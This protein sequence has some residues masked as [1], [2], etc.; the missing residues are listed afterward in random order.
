MLKY[1]FALVDGVPADEANTEI[2]CRRVCHVEPTLYGEMY[3]FTSDQT[4]DDT[5]YT[6]LAIGAH[7]DSTY[8][9]LP[10][11]IQVL[12]CTYHDG[13]GGMSLL[14]DGFHV[15]EQLRGQSPELFDILTRVVVPHEYKATLNSQH[16]ITSLDSILKIHPITKE[17]IWFRYNHYDRAPINSI[18]P[19]E[20]PKF[21]AAINELSKMV[22]N[23]KQE[24][25]F[26]LKP[27]TVLFMDNFRV[28]H[29]R[30]A[31]TGKRCISGCYL[32]RDDWMS[33]ARVFGL[34]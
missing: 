10:M 22:E 23:P 11:G 14:L 1:G 34:V 26:K 7:T 32:P 18:P 24:M 31:F 12:H 16:H 30:S 19:E 15:A 8:F 6:N 4:M 17:L 28:M 13:D 9:S 5:A 3:S 29:G 33:H 2:A 25:W 21:Y 27:G 20:L